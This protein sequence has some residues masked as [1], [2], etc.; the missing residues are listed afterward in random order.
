MFIEIYKYIFIEIYVANLT[1]PP[2]LLRWVE[3]N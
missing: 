2:Y 1:A 3:C